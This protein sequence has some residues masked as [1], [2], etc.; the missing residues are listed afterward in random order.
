[1][2][3]RNYFTKSIVY[4][5]IS[6]I[7]FELKTDLDEMLFWIFINKNKNRCVLPWIKP[8]SFEETYIPSRQHSLD[9][10]MMI[11]SGRLGV[12][13]YMPL[14]P[15]KKGMNFF[16]VRDS[17][18]SYCLKLVIHTGREGRFV[19]GEGFAFNI[20]NELLSNYQHKHHRVY[21]DNCYT[22]LKLARYLLSTG[23]DLIGT[24]CRTSIG[25]PHIYTLRLGQGD[26]FKLANVDGIVNL[27]HRFN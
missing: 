6:F 10:G 25:F 1:M 5:F 14:K 23:T 15:T 18:I 19:S 9:E 26:N 12:L 24:I 7:G 2:K 13:Q 11:F 8:N 17:V 3:S 22:Y 16:S 20:A 21:T 27:Y 4:I